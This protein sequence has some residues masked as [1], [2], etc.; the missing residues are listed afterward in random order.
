MNLFIFIPVNHYLLHN[1]TGIQITEQLDYSSDKELLGADKE[2]IY[3]VYVYNVNNYAKVYTSIII[4]IL[5]IQLN[6]KVLL[7]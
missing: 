7:T 3:I 5:Y 2:Y 1:M 6:L 4:S